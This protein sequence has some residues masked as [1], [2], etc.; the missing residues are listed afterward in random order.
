M[1]LVQHW[2]LDDNAAS[3][4]VVAT[5][6]T[7]ATLVGGDNT[8][9]VHVAGPGGSIVSGFLLNGT[10]DE[11]DISASSISFATTVAFSVSLWFKRSGTTARLIGGTTANGRILG[12]SDTNIQVVNGS[13]SS[14]NY[15]VPSMGTSS[16]HHL[17][18]TR[19]TGNSCRVFLDGTESSS[20]SQSVTGTIALTSIG[21]Q[22]SLFSNGFAVA[23]AKVFDSDESANV[24]ALYAE[25]V[26]GGLSIPVAVYNFRQQGMM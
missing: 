14:L 1:S 22:N 25:G 3:T 12:S 17:L 8:S 4:T 21:K 26:A 5:V 2:K 6:G 11:I 9:T 24:A 23:W 20:G 16:W 7:N 13:G 18:V 10:D 19:T 15:T